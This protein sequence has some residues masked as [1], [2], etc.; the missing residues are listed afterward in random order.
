MRGTVLGQRKEHWILL[1]LRAAGLLLLPPG[2]S[3]FVWFVVTA[4]KPSPGG[5]RTGTIQGLEGMD[6]ETSKETRGS[7]NRS[8]DSSDLHVR[9]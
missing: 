8:K 7:L 6:R 1:N 3:G 4:S 5:V 2:S 9:V